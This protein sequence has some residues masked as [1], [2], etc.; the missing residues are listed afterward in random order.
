MLETT[1]KEAKG[2][3]AS[4][5]RDYRQTSGEQISGGRLLAKALKNEGVDVIFTLTG[6]EIMRHLQWLCRGGDPRH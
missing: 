1:R 2:K 6:G 3:E 4:M 5:R